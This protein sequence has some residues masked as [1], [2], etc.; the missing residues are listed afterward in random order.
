MMTSFM[1]FFAGTVI[2]LFLLMAFGKTIIFPML[3]AAAES[4][5]KLIAEQLRTYV[6]EAQLIGEN[7]SYEADIVLPSGLDVNIVPTS[8]G[9]KVSVSSSK[10]FVSE[11]EYYGPRIEGYT[12]KAFGYHTHGMSK[13]II[14]KPA[15]SKTIGFKTTSELGVVGYWK[16]DEGI[17]NGIPST[18]VEDSSG[19]ENHGEVCGTAGEH[20]KWYEDAN[21]KIIALNFAGDTPDKTGGVKAYVRIK[22]DYELDTDFAFTLEALINPR[23]CT[24]SSGKSSTIIGKWYTSPSYGDYIFWITPDS[25]SQNCILKLVVAWH[26]ESD[27]YE[28]DEIISSKTVLKG[29]WSHVVATFDNGNAT[30]YIS[31]T[32]VAE[33]ELKVKH[34]ELAEYEQCSANGCEPYDDVYIGALWSGYYAFNGL[35]DEVK[36]YAYALDNNTVKSNCEKYKDKY[37]LESCGQT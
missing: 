14:L 5:P 37:K 31:G 35:I 2:S 30:L 3:G 34:T 12:I 23:S 15:G 21:N 17:K 18:W 11:S 25:N 8:T 7:A 9:F 16:F 10:F 24:D 22:D 19:N 29:K 27:Q 36:I 1:I 26:N 32:K 13:L 28:Q 6:L 4:T 33:K 20:V